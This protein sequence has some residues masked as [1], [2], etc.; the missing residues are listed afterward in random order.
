MNADGSDQRK[1]ASFPKT[2]YCPDFFPS[3]DG[4]RIAFETVE[5]DGRSEIDLIDLDSGNNQI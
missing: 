1:L 3:P 2:G 4:K 5:D